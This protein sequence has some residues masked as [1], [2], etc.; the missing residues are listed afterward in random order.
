MYL[1]SMN[2]Q[3]TRSFLIATDL[4]GTFLGGDVHSKEKLYSALQTAEDVC[5]VFVTGRGLESVLPLFEIAHMPRPEYIICDVGATIVHGS[6]LEPVNPIQEEIE[7]AWPGADTVRSA[8]EPLKGLR[9]QEVPQQ[10]R[11]SYYFDQDADMKR[12]ADIADQLQVDIIISHGKYV[13][14]LPAGT[15]K[16]STLKKLVALL[17]HP[18][19]AI[20]VAGDTLN[21]LSLFETGFKGVVV[22]DA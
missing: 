19:E 12:I 8:F 16:G 4:D 13:D 17:G 15:N 1:C 21:D 7:G 5:L 3:H 11:S 10:R 14:V 2:R 22:G 9:Y 6:S 20:L 18:G